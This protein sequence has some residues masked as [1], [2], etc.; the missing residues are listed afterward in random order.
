MIEFIQFYTKNIF[1]LAVFM[2]IGFVIAILDITIR[3]TVKGVY[4]NVRENMK[5]RGGK[6]NLREGLDASKPTSTDSKDATADNG[7]AGGSEGC[8]KDCNAVEELRKRLTDLI[9]D[10]T[11]LQS[12]VKRNNEIIK[13]QQESIE[14]LKIN[15]QA[16]VAASSNK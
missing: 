2:M 7:N 6:A 9:S 15:V 3:K 4:L 11:K 16:L 12:D 8:P 13:K 14:Q 5:N 10:A 1:H